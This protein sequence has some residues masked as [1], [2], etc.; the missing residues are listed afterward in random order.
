[1]AVFAGVCAGVRVAVLV[2]VRVDVLVGLAVLV[3]VRVLVSVDATIFVASGV[4]VGPQ[5]VSTVKHSNTIEC[6]RSFRILLLY[7][8]CR[9]A[10]W[11]CRSPSF[12]CI[13][14]DRPVGLLLCYHR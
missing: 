4:V 11:N 2:G 5:A 10:R 7:H 8:F 9:P 13:T 1:M 3:G 14:C 6:M 12:S